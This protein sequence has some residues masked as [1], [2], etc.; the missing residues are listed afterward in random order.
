[1]TYKQRLQKIVPL[2]QEQIEMIIKYWGDKIPAHLL[3]KNLAEMYQWFLDTIE[4]VEIVSL[5]EQGEK[6]AYGNPGQPLNE[7]YENASSFL[8]NAKTYGIIAWQIVPYREYP[9]LNGRGIVRIA[10][11]Y[12]EISSTYFGENAEYDIRNRIKIR[13]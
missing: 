5:L 11:A 9:S 2:I 7:A 12:F 1:M 13:Y 10:S 3:R 6:G 4:D 8:G